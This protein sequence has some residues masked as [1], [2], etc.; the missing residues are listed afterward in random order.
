RRSRL[1]SW[2]WRVRRSSVT[3]VLRAAS[4]CSLSFNSLSID[5]DLRFIGVFMGVYCPCCASPSMTDYLRANR[6][7]ADIW[8]IVRIGQT[9]DPRPL[10]QLVFKSRLADE[11]LLNVGVGSS[12][13]LVRRYAERKLTRN[14]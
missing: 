5:I 4:T 1:P 10:T 12:F 9:T 13:R 8:K 3:L 11:F 7:M 14:L 6:I 2:A